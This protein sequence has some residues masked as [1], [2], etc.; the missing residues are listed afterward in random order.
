MPEPLKCGASPVLWKGP[1]G[2]SPCPRPFSGNGLFHPDLWPEGQER[3]A[4]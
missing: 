2:S 1:F 3:G 4:I